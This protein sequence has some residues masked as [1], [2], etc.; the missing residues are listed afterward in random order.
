MRALAVASF[1][2]VWLAA[3]GDS[4]ARDAERFDSW[5][6]TRLGWQRCEEFLGPPI[7]YRRPALHPAVVG[8]LQILLSAT[9][10]LALGDSR[11]ATAIKA[12]RASEAGLWSPSPSGRGPG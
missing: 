2:L 3:G 4:C 5:R 9:A 11:R 12:R 10:M 6:Q 8:M 7:E 1:L